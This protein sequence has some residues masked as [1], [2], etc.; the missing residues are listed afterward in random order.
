MGLMPVGPPVD[1]A[2]VGG[3]PVPAA[4]QPVVRRLLPP[5]PQLDHAGLGADGGDLAV[6]G[7]AGGDPNEDRATQVAATSSRGVR[8]TIGGYG[9]RVCETGQAG[10]R[11]VEPSKPPCRR[12]QPLKE[13]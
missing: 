11:Q 7:A 12:G 5:D 3:V 6:V 8:M 10:E 9:C 4:G 13:P 1:D 2:Q